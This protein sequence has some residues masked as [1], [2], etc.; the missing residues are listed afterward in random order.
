HVG[1][2]RRGPPLMKLQTHKKL[3]SRKSVGHKSRTNM[4][5][6]NPS[7]GCFVI[8][9]IYEMVVFLHTTKPEG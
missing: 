2:D 8:I 3:R 4:N 6:N 5:Q 1:R 7:R 9:V